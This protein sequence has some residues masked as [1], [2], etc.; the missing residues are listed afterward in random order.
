MCPRSKD[1]HLYNSSRRWL[2]R[3]RYLEP[4]GI[5]THCTPVL[6][7]E[8]LI[9]G[10]IKGS[11]LALP[12][13]SF[14]PEL[15]RRGER[16]SDTGSTGVGVVFNETFGIYHD[17]EGNSGSALRDDRRQ[18]LYVFSVCWHGMQSCTCDVHSLASARMLLVKHSIYENLTTIGLN[19]QIL[20]LISQ[21]LSRAHLL[22]T[23][24]DT[25]TCR[26]S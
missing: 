18:L 10:Q 12:H 22:Q 9:E 11:G 13:R 25:A 5:T 19:S 15:H 6:N 26:K 1:Q 20:H 16:H 23:S 4:S 21:D 7:N 2:D 8:A 3:T 24:K 14:Q 17:L